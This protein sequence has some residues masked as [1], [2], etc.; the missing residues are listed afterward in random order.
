MRVGPDARVVQ[1]AVRRM[2][3][4]RLRHLAGRGD[5]RR[6]GSGFEITRASAL[7]LPYPSGTA[8]VVISLDVLQHVPLGGGDVTAL[9][10]MRRVLKP[11]GWLFV[12]TNA[13]SFPATADDHEYQFHRYE[14]RELQRQAGGSRLRGA[15]S[16]SR[17]RSARVWRRFR[18]SCARGAC[19]R[20]TIMAFSRRATV[21][22]RGRLRRSGRGFV[23]RGGG[24][25]RR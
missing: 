22:R 7:A 19:R 1:S 12:R 2:A 11:G 10:E 15:S 25:A 21:M 17:E 8:D 23:S 3:D 5:G 13:Q 16:E 6:D 14:P 20:R 9:R 18:V 24:S 4:T